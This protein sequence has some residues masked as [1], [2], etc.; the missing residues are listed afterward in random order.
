MKQKD[1]ILIASVTT[2]GYI[3]WKSRQPKLE[4]KYSTGIAEGIDYVFSAYG[5]K[6]QGTRLFSDDTIRD[7]QMGNYGFVVQDKGD[8]V[9][10]DL[11]GAN[12]N[13]KWEKLIPKSPAA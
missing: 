5:Y 11:F 13:L 8:S 4:Y 6:I 3:Y 9:A 7:Q 12:G 1:A 10:F 2:A